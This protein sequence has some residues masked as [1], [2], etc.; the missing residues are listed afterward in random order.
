MSILEVAH[1]A[2]VSRATVSRVMNGTAVVD[3]QKV[4]LVREAI[5]KIGYRPPDVRRGPKVGSRRAQEV[6]QIGLL[7]ADANAVSLYHLP[8]Y[9]RLLHGLQRALGKGGSNLV[10]LN[11]EGGRFPETSELD[12][13]DGV[14]LLG[15]FGSLRPEQRS[16]LRRRPVVWLMRMHSDDRHFFDHVFYNNES[17]G[18]IA[19]H[20]LLDRGHRSVAFV[21]SRPEHPAFVARATT[22]KDAVERSGATAH[23]EISAGGAQSNGSDGLRDLVD[24]MLKHDP[25]PTGLFVPNDRQ[26]VGV[27]TSLAAR[28]VLPGRDID[29]IGCDNETAL[30]EH[31]SPRSTSI[32]LNLEEVG[33]RGVE[34]MQRRI[35]NEDSPRVTVLV[36]PTL[37]VG[38][39]SSQ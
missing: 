31:L 8:V 4:Q 14:F 18:R 21:N 7:A 9:P 26:L 36:E 22:F 32:D 28:G 34:Q 13:L 37:V 17:I 2:G 3:P 6:G 10:L 35:E 12:R 19:A 33:A 15:K 11:M 25:R 38:D 1:L 5:D 29:V 27:Y 39:V 20:Y 24:R 30:L 16:I 23:L